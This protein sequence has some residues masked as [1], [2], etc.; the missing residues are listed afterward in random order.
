MVVGATYR[1][2]TDII[3]IHDSLRAGQVV[4]FIAVD[5][6]RYDNLT[7]LTFR[8]RETGCA[9]QL[10]WLDSEAD[11]DWCEFESVE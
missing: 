9:L 4:E 11:I 3:S 10:W 5:Y 1:V 2:S 7:V 8:E 6:S